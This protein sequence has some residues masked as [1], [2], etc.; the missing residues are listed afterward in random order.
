VR[1]F[2]GARPGGLLWNANR[3]ENYPGFP[4]GV[5]GPDL[6]RAFLAQGKEA[7]GEEPFRLGDVPPVKADPT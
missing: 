3:V 4:G 1:L 5:T 7:F 2:E 6:V